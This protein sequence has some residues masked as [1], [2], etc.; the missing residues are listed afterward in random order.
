[1]FSYSEIYLL[2]FE[3]LECFSECPKFK[4]SDTEW[5][6]NLGSIFSPE[7]HLI[8]DGVNSM[9]IVVICGGVVWFLICDAL[10]PVTLLSISS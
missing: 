4:L 3:C 10:A 7:A 2:L 8:F 9:L 1:M 6:I 5:V